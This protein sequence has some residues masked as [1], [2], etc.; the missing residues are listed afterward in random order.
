MPNAMPFRM[1]LWALSLLTAATALPVAAAPAAWVTVNHVSLRYRL[2]GDGDRAIV[3]L[4]E[5]GLP[6]EAWDDVVPSI[7]KPDRLLLR[8]DPRGIGLSEKFRKPVT[9]QDEVE[10][11]RGLLD[12]VL[13]GRKV[14]LVGGALG[15]S[16]ALEFAAQYPDRVTAVMVTSPSAVTQT[17]PPRPRID[18]AVDPAGAARETERTL[19]VIFPKQFRTDPA[20]WQRLR[21]M[22]AVND[23][24][25]EV[26]TEALI[27]TTDFSDVL[28]RIQCPTLLVATSVFP[29]PV[30]SVKALAEKIPH[31]E[32][33]VIASGHL[34]FME[35]P[36]LALPVLETFLQENKP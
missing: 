36:Q 22:V 26:L 33:K 16:V 6:L 20:T 9:M 21:A 19:D 31:G 23:F 25:S 8:Y 27:N 5:S 34:A 1:F 14:T 3:L 12:A 2:D 30:A 7:L 32:F 24:D 29:R 11:L 10:D 15:G 4:Q 18:P 17:R 35:A 13:P 28:P